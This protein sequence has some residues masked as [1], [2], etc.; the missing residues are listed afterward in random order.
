M[1]KQEFLDRLRK[2]LSGLPLAEREERL[3]FYS[4]MIDDRMEEGLTE[5]EAVAAIGSLEEILNS[6][7][8]LKEKKHFK[9]WIVGLL[10]LGSPLWFSLVVTAAA[11]ALSVYVSFWSVI[12]ALWAIFGALAGCALGGVLGGAAVSCTGR[13]LSGIALIGMGLL[14]AG[15]TVFFFYL[16]KAASSGMVLLTKKMFKWFFRK[17]EGAL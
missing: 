7:G 4:E 17:K 8:K 16:S 15:M 2:G 9:P 12:I 6:V 13:L 10:I 14:C 1:N 11:V 3:L 5:E